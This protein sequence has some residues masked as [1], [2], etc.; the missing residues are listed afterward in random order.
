MRVPW[1][2]KLVLSL[3]LGKGVDSEWRF[4]DVSRYLMQS[5]LRVKRRYSQSF[6]AI[7]IMDILRIS[8]DVDL[9]VEA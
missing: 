6:T 9:Q 2:V 5:H 3:G 8:F 1:I 4:T 7:P